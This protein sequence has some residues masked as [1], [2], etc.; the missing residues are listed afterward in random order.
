[1]NHNF[2]RITLSNGVSHYALGRAE[3]VLY[4]RASKDWRLNLRKTI[5]N[6]LEFANTHFQRPYE[7]PFIGGGGKIEFLELDDEPAQKVENSCVF[8]L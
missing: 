2:L 1:M 5:D 4:V 8:M 6:A 3:I 7:D